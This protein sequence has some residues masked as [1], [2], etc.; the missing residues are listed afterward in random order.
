M[1]SPKVGR[2]VAWV[3]NIQSLKRVMQRAKTF[4]MKD[5][6]NHIGEVTSK[7]HRLMFLNGLSVR[8][9]R[10][11]HAIESSNPGD[12]TICF[13]LKVKQFSVREWTAAQKHA[14]SGVCSFY[15]R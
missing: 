13:W 8:V 10:G 3:E 9:D 5:G 14:F 6:W 7:H 1:C 12:V 15:D 4:V 2:K 11:S